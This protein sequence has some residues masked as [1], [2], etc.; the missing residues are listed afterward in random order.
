[1]KFSFLI[2]EFLKKLELIVRMGVVFIEGGA[3]VE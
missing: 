3:T 2:F 1:M